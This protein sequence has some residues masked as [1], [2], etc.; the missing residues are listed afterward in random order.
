MALEEPGMFP[1]KFVL[2]L[3][4]IIIV[5]AVLLSFSQSMLESIQRL[6]ERITDFFSGL[7]P[8]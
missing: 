4:L 1:A 8:T 2:G 5:F 7:I 6:G 3:L